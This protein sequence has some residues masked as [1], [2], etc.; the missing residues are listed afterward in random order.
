[1]LFPDT[2][3]VEEPLLIDR[4]FLGKTFEWIIDMSCRRPRAFIFLWLSIVSFEG[5]GA[6]IKITSQGGLL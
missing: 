3:C 2:V 1:M 4:F 5:V 6:I